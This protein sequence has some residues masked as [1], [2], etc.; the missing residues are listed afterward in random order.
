MKFATRKPNPSAAEL[1]VLY[2]D[3]GVGKTTLSALIAAQAMPA[4]SVATENADA[5][6][7][8]VNG[9]ID[10]VDPPEHPRDVLRILGQL[11]DGRHRYRTVIF[12]SVSAFDTM[13]V[14]DTINRFAKSNELR[15]LN[16][17]SGGYGKGGDDVEDAHAE[18]GLR[19]R[20]IA[21]RGI[22]VIVIAHQAT[23]TITAADGESYSRWSLDLKRAKHAKHYL[24]EADVVARMYAPYTVQA[25]GGS[26]VAT[27][28]GRGVVID[29]NANPASESKSRSRIMHGVTVWRDPTVAP[30]DFTGGKPA[31]EGE[32]KPEAKPASASFDDLRAFADEKIPREI[33]VRLSK[34][35]MDRVAEAAVPWLKESGY[36]REEIRAALIVAHENSE[37]IRA[38]VDAAED[39]KP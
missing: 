17:I 38:F 31:P 34:L 27:S 39:L 32:A 16:V 19:L 30:F 5:I 4:I 24:N 7:S 25:K 20:Q 10:I 1:I 13:L 26:S 6:Y 18:A 14:T 23:E 11:A 9:E 15:S 3:R 36:T 29:T 22:R 35:P 8:K 28:A 37:E 12:E 2:G 21:N 33:L